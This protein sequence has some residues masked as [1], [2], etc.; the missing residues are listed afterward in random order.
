MTAG[1]ALERD[2]AAGYNCSYLA[3]DSPRAFD[4]A[5]YLL[6]SGVGVG[7][8]IERQFTSK[9]PDIP[10]T[11][12]DSDTVIKV[13]DSKIGWA[14][15]LKELIALLYGGQVP[16]FDYSA[17][18]PAGAPLKVFGGRASGPEPLQRMLDHVVKVFKGAHGNL[19]SIEAHDIMCYIAD[20]VVVGY[21]RR[22]FYCLSRLH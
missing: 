20:C 12:Y 8:S 1:P 2:E 19:T 10:E 21:R 7:Y 22:I 14:R 11:F 6:L 3:V 17:I 18:R 15:A 9:L 5:L 4:E 13:A 16:T